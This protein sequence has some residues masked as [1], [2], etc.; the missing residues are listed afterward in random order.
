[1][2]EEDLIPILIL[3][4]Y[5]QKN[6]GKLWHYIKDDV[7]IYKGVTGKFYIYTGPYTYPVKGGSIEDI[8]TWLE[9]HHD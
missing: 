7:Q 3:L 4:G 5:K 6:S 8:M 1:M 9:G 2:T